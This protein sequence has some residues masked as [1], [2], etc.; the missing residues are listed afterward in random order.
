MQRSARLL[1]P[2]GNED[3]HSTPPSTLPTAT[4]VEP[5]P[6]STTAIRPAGGV[7]IISVAPQ[8]ASRASSSPL[9]TTVSWP[10][11][12]RSAASSAASLAAVRIAAVATTFIRS[13]PAA[14]AVAICASTT[15]A[16]CSIV[17]GGIVPS[18]ASRRPMRVNARSWST[19]SSRSPATSATRTR[20]VLDP[21][22]MQ[23]QRMTV[24]RRLP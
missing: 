10:V 17:S 23:A 21:M 22:S 3:A 5:P 7:A 9:R 20:V 15:A 1:E 14:R 12:A 4:S 13:A 6:T 24:G 11:R 2:T 18:A 19:A 8:K 16:T